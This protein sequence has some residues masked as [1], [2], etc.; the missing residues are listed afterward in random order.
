MHILLRPDP[1]NI[2]LFYERGRDL[3]DYPDPVLRSYSYMASIYTSDRLIRSRDFL[4]SG[5]AIMMKRHFAEH[6]IEMQ[7][8][9]RGEIEVS[10]ACH[11][12]L[13]SGPKEVVHSE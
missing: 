8:G 10:E 12:R 1:N 6:G 4:S 9:V 3:L 11:E 5:I 7:D 2:G 13:K